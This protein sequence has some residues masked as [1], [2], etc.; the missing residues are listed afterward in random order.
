MRSS[1][2]RFPRLAVARAVVLAGVLNV[3]LAG[4]L[5]AA[6]PTTTSSIAPATTPGVSVTTIALPAGASSGRMYLIACPKPTDCVAGG[7]ATFA[8]GK[9]RSIISVETGGVW[10]A[11][12]VVGATMVHL[13]CPRTGACVGVGLR[14]LPGPVANDSLYSSYLIV[15]HGST[16]STPQTVPATGLGLNPSYVVTAIACPRVG[17]CILSGTLIFS[18]THTKVFVVTWHNGQWSAPH[19]L[20]S[21]ALGSGAQLTSLNAL[22][23]VG[24]WCQAV[25]V[26]MDAHQRIQP[27]TITDSNGRWHMTH[28]LG[29]FLASTNTNGLESI[30]CSAVETCVAGGYSAP[31][32]GIVESP[33]FVEENHARWSR[34]YEVPVSISSMVT[35]L[36]CTAATRCA[37]VIV[38][39]AGESLVGLTTMRV[40]HRWSA[41]LVVNVA[42][43]ATVQGLAVGCVPGQC[44]IAGATQSSAHAPF[45]PTLFNV[46]FAR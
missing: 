38:N 40:S 23:C 34:P 29:A 3:S 36:S 37:A 42:K 1:P 30:S 2:R 44:T 21:S 25:G 39:A 10:A 18:P 33:L 32:T 28:E 46:K 14:L 41:P 8:G 11:P 7:L 12:Q 27:F 4:T 35:S 20:S 5:A 24:D 6:S 17:W 9:Q 31:T 15:Q 45:Q 19:F 13:A 22:S 26:F 16:W 43:Q